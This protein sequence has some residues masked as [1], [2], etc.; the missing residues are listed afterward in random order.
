M[1]SSVD[2]AARRQRRRRGLYLWLTAAAA[3]FCSALFLLF[4]MVKG[5]SEQPG[6]PRG[7]GLVGRHDADLPGGEFAR[8][9][10]HAVSLRQGAAAP[11]GGLTAQLGF[12]IR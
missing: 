6:Q 12:H 4:S 8:V 11:A 5:P 10:Q 2:R 9:Q 1:A 3:F 7:K